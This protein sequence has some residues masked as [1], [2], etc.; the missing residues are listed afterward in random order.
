MQAFDEVHRAIHY[1]HDR[2]FRVWI[3]P[4]FLFFFA[5]VVFVPVAV[6]W[7]QYLIFGLPTESFRPLINLANPPNP[8][9]CAYAAVH[10]LDFEVQP[11]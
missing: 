2:R 8:H 10:G 6:A 5:V 11:N 3:N 1:P 9:G 4:R 7:G